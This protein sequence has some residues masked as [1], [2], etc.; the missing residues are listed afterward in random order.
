MAAAYFDLECDI[1]M[2]A[3]DTQ[4]QRPNVDRIKVLGANVIAVKEETQT[5]RSSRRRF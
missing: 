1:Y 5:L 2:G 4:K 3:V